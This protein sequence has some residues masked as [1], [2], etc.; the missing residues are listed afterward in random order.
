MKQPRA[1]ADM[2]DRAHYVLGQ[3]EA[4][5]TRFEILGSIR[6]G[7]AEVNDIEI[8]VEPKYELVPAGLFGENEPRNL[9]FPA[10]QQKLAD[11]VIEHRP[12]VN[13]RGAFGERYM[14]IN[15]VIPESP[16][17]S[18]ERVPVDFFVCLPP[19]QWGVLKVIR[20]GP[21]EFSHKVVSPRPYGHLPMGM[22]V[23]SGQLLDR[24]NA[25]E[26][27]DEQTFFDQIGLDY[28]EPEARA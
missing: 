14:R 16:E 28:I 17:L 2:I 24:G 1:R 12:D 13:G 11:G 9:L 25:L 23:A 6:R 27:P 26:T 19:A 7:K 8:L 15:W 21:A 10:M 22:A 3:I 20:T 18:E 5:V 4:Y